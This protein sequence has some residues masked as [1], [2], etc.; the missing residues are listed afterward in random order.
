M[1]WG[2]LA[3]AR[4]RVDLLLAGGPTA[5]ALRQRAL[6]EAR[7]GASRAARL[8]AQRAVQVDPRRWDALLDVG[9]VLCNRGRFRDGLQLLERG[10]EL[11]ERSGRALLVLAAGQAVAGRLHEASATLDEADRLSA[12]PRR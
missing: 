4:E 10:V 11:S 5:E 8:L 1:E 6:L 7:G 2:D 3:G 9:A 12:A